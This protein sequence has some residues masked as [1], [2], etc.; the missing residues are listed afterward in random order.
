MGAGLVHGWQ[1]ATLVGF[2]CRLAIGLRGRRP[3]V[4]VAYTSSVYAI[5]AAAEKAARVGP[6]LSVGG[7]HSVTFPL[8]AGLAAVHGPLNLLHFDAHPDLYHAYEGHPR[9]HASPSAT[10]MERGLAGHAARRAPDV[11]ALGIR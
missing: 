7:D 4:R 8:V 9:S 6:L 2:L 10:I 3:F 11:H 1:A 5:A